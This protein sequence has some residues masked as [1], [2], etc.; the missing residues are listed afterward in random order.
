MN[1]TKPQKKTLVVLSN[2]ADKEFQVVVT[3]MLTELRRMDEHNENFHNGIEN[4]RKVPKRRH[5]ASIV[6][7]LKKYI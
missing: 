2:L 3:E 1:K 4:I 5:R 7:E 6:T